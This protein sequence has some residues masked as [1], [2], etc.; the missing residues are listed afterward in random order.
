MDAETILCTPVKGGGGAGAAGS[1]P[2]GDVVLATPGSGAPGRWSGGHAAVGRPM[3]CQ[4]CWWGW[5]PPCA[6]AP[7]LAP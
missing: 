4:G 3:C 2:C 7:R 1:S 5:E 6:L